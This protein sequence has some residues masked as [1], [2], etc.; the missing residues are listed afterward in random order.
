MCNAHVLA[1]QQ[2][3]HNLVWR[4]T[5]QTQQRQNLKY[6]RSIRANAYGIGNYVW[7]FCRYN[8]HKGSPELMKAWCGPHKVAQV[9][10]KDG[11]MSWTTVHSERLKPH[12][13]GPTDWVTTPTSDGDIAAIMNQ[14]SSQKKTPDDCSQPSYQEEEFLSEDVSAPPRQRH[15]KD[16]RLRTRVREGGSRPFYQQFDYFTDKESELSDILLSPNQEPSQS[17]GDP[18][19]WEKSGDLPHNAISQEE[20]PIT[21]PVMAEESLFSEHEVDLTETISTIPSVEF[22]AD[23]CQ[24]SLAGTSAPLLTNP[25]LTDMV[26]SFSIWPNNEQSSNP[27]IE[28]AWKTPHFSNTLPISDASGHQRKRSGRRSR[29]PL[30]R[31]SRQTRRDTVRTKAKGLRGE[32]PRAH[33]QTR[34]KN[35][36]CQ[37]KSLSFRCVGTECPCNHKFGIT[38]RSSYNVLPSPS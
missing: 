23:T 24:T 1:H 8:P 12:N 18:L 11:Y 7:V 4:N 15:G 31:S 28:R 10:R 21:T 13:N 25:S 35:A 34:E 32:P 20:L 37:R 17:Q 6:Y 29:L 38:S 14:S 16:T 30:G 26:S 27:A 33:Q 22:Q 36:L 3:I 2:E 9:H 19:P 5:H